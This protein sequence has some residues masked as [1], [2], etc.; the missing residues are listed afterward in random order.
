MAVQI[1][2][3]SH[4]RIEVQ[5]AASPQQP[6]IY[7]RKEG[8]CTTHKGME[9]QHDRIVNEACDAWRAYEIKS[10]TVSRVPADE[11]PTN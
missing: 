2:K 5:T 8:K 7:F 1:V 10:F 9:R 6:I 11:V 3:H 4:Y